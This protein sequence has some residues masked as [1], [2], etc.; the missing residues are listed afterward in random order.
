MAGLFG[1]GRNNKR[2]ISKEETQKSGPS[3]YFDLFIRKFWDFLKLDLIYLIFSIP[4]IIIIGIISSFFITLFAQNIGLDV[5]LRAEALN[6]IYMLL[7][8][9]ILGILGGGASSAGL[10]SVTKSFVN[11]THAFV[12]SDFFDSFKSNFIQAT[13]VFIIDMLVLIIGGFAYLFYTLSGGT[14][15]IIFRTLIVIFAV[16]FSMMH[17]YIYPI[18]ISFKLKIKDIY[19]NAFLLVM[20]RLW[21]NVFSFLV[22]AIIIYAV[23]TFTISSPLGFAVLIALYLPLLAFTKAFMTKNVI[24]ELL[25]KPSVE[26]SETKE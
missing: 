1:F 26:A 25:T 6:A 15:G 8:M 17:M 13:I 14:A 12:F 3:L 11:D 10:H 20:A 5:F 18:M 19:R 21:W 7:T 9:I 23:M 22:C 2:G 16:I 24:F 4:S